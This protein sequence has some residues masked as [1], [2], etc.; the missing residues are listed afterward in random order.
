MPKDCEPHP[1]IQKPDE[2]TSIGSRRRPQSPPR[3]HSTWIRHAG[4][5]RPEELE[6]VILAWGQDFAESLGRLAASGDTAVC[7]EIVQEITDPDDPGQKGIALSPA[8][9]SWLATS[10]ASLDI[11]QYVY[12]DPQ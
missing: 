2:S 12:S 8:L 6:P 11:D 10:H 1:Q 4:H 3:L 5:A 7:L 9:L